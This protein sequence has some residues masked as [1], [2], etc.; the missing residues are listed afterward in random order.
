MHEK[1]LSLLTMMMI[2]FF[3]YMR[4]LGIEVL[5]LATLCALLSSLRKKLSG[6][7]KFFV[8]DI[9]LRSC[10]SISIGLYPA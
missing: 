10:Y 5:N 7:N 9:T 4:Y 8:P 2:I 3:W 1:E 6:I